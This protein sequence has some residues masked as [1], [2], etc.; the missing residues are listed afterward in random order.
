[1]TVIYN[2]KWS[3]YFREVQD[4]FKVKRVLRKKQIVTS[5]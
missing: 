3:T 4:S 5:P 2:K 1:M